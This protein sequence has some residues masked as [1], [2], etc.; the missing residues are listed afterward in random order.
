MA[1]GT[2][3][4]IC[5]KG[6]SFSLPPGAA[7]QLKQALGARILCR[8]GTLWVSEYRRAE[9]VVLQTGQSASVASDRAI[10]LSGLPC[11]QVEIQQPESQP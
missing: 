5:M 2:I 1:T 7:V 3:S 4:F 6:M 8:A 10:V 11:A 9:D